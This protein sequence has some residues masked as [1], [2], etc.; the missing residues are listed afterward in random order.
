MK[1]GYT[2][3][4]VDPN[5]YYLSTIPDFNPDESL[6]SSVIKLGIHDADIGFHI[7]SNHDENFGKLFLKVRVGEDKVLVGAFVHA[8]AFFMLPYIRKVEMIGTTPCNLGDT[9]FIFNNDHSLTLTRYIPLSQIIEQQVTL[10]IAMMYDIVKAAKLLKQQTYEFET[11]ALVTQEAILD[12]KTEMRMYAQ[13]QC[14]GCREMYS[15]DHPHTC[16][17][18]SCDCLDRV[19]RGALKHGGKWPYSQTIL[20]IYKRLKPHVFHLKREF[21]HSIAWN[22]YHNM[23][24]KFEQM[25]SFVE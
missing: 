4:E 20:E 16:Y 13:G 11:L 12:V 3:S 25:P 10:T 22:V 14:K 6:F 8:I 9:S 7:H 15:S 24:Y 19:L 18:M 17:S 23:R 2:T 1:H 5:G 21:R